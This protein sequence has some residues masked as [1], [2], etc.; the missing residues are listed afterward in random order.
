MVFKNH[1]KWRIIWCWFKVLIWLLPHIRQ[2]G[3]VKWM[4]WSFQL[5]DKSFK[6]LVIKSSNSIRK[7][8]LDNSNGSPIDFEYYVY[9]FIYVSTFENRTMELQFFFLFHKL[10]RS[11]RNPSETI[12]KNPR[13]IHSIFIFAPKRRKKKNYD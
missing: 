13:L 4:K 8:I 5:M 6:M 2:K 3:S 9:A 10:N 11:N 12:Y 1:F 7:L